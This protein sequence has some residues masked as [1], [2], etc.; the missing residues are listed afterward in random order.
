MKE[1][2]DKTIL[3]LGGGTGGHIYP[4]LAI[5]E[6]LREMTPDFSC[7][8]LVSN[9]PGDAKIMVDEGLDF[10]AVPTR[11]L[12]MHPLQIMG[13]LKGIYT[14][15]RQV[16]RLIREF[17]IACVVGTGG[18]VSG[19][20]VLAATA[21]KLPIGLVNLDAVPGRA[22]QRITRYATKVFSAYETRRLPDAELIGLPLRKQSIGAVDMVAARLELGL[23]AD[24]K[25]MLVVG[26]STGANSIN[27]AMPV[28][29]GR[30]DF[31]DVISGWQIIHITGMRDEQAVRGM[32]EQ[33]RVNS[34]VK[35]RVLGYCDQMG[36]AWSSADVALSR[37][38]ASSVAEAWA[39]GTP[40]IFL[41]YP[42][43]KDQH[44]RLNAQPMVD[45]GGAVV[46]EDFIEAGANAESLAGV[47]RELLG[48]DGKL[49]RMRESLAIGGRS[50][51]AGIVAKWIR[52]VVD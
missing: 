30:N 51:G 32:Y 10:T 20:A 49:A 9:R 22:N 11:P 46:V 23:A 26:G 17:D 52:S 50:D 41:P 34:D 40:S 24:R 15:K 19:P 36:L 14:G 44:Q 2:C 35:V 47:L 1:T 16:G 39:N 7:H 25:T 37:G 31:A 13:V 6:R 18:F 12:S 45:V 3:F 48:K 42:Y 27:Q 38:G 21:A 8:F 5:V 29:V 33:A 4:N 28:L 43:H